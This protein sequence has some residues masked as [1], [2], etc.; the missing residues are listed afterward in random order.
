MPAV[1]RRKERIDRGIKVR[2][3]DV[4][5]VGS[6]REALYLI[7][8]RTLPVIVLLALP[9]FLDAYWQGVLMRAAVFALLALSWD[10]LARVGMVSLG[11][12]LF[13]GLGAYA[14]GVL[15]SYLGFPVWLSIPAAV[16]LGGLASTVVLLPV[17]R[18]R[19]IYF[20][21]ITLVFPLLFHRIIEATAILGGTQGLPG[22]SPLP[23]RMF[24]C[25]LV[26]VAAWVCLFGLRRLMN[27]DY[28]LV[29][30]GIHDNDQTVKASGINIY[31]KKAEA[32]FLAAAI[33]AF[34][35]AVMAHYQGSAGMSMFALDY[36][37]LPIAAAVVGGM[38]TF[39]GAMLGA[40]LLLPAYEIL[41]GIGTLRVVVYAV[42]LT[43]FVVVL[44]EGVF[45]YLARKYN[46]F[47]RWKTV[48]R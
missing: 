1:Q 9:P 25:Y 23:G 8:P 46:Q 22:L 39:A 30:T 10:L 31:R 33:G 42:M 13:V 3:E 48:S 40:F 37:I 12:A 29:L 21:M 5:A 16:V 35:G 4:Y 15:N 6:W 7:S 24:E 2:S 28:G 11:Q 41:R 18:L 38:G 43:V 26:I 36:S 20:S 47:E 27:S 14:S 44:P 17:L 45:H 34:C 32:L 19:G